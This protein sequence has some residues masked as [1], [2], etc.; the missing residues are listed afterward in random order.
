M[1]AGSHQGNEAALELGMMDTGVM[2]HVLVCLMEV[3]GTAGAT[4][5]A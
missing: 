2:V 5:C 3:G 4:P 1:Q